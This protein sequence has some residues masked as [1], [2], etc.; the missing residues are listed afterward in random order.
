MADWE[1]AP[2]RSSTK[3]GWEDAPTAKGKWEDVTA[4]VASKA[5]ESASVP[6]D[7]SA[8]IMDVA[9]PTKGKSIFERGVKM[10]PPNVDYEKNLETM[11]RSGS[12]ESVMFTPGRQLEAVDKR[13]AAAK[14]Q[15]AAAAEKAAEQA[16]TKKFLQERQAEVEGYGPL[17]LAQDIGGGLAKGVVGLGQSAVGLAQLGTGWLPEDEAINPLQQPKKLQ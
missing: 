16:A 1:D 11:R 14:K 10:D 13:I 8:A 6:E 12:P 4:P 9:G 15:A 7:L 5:V 3:G 2:A 17:G